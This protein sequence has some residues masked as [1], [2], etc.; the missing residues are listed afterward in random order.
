MMVTAWYSD[1]CRLRSPFIICHSCCALIG[2]V[3]LGFPSNVGVRY[4][5]AFLAVSGANT[6]ISAIV[7][8]QANNIRG[9]WKRA[10]CSATLVLAGNI[11]GI[12]GTTVFRTQDKPKYRPGILTTMTA[13]ALIITLSLLL[14]YKFIRANRR[15]AAGG[16]V[17]GSLEGFRYT[18]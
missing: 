16:K 1:R 12:I 18:L 17:I 15:A 9:Q 6:N 8:W 3:L 10:I 14:D 5:G 11:G 7:T 13:C 2:L 4:F